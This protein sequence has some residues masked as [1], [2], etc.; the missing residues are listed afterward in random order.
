M[1]EVTGYDAAAAYAD[2]QA[3]LVSLRRKV[4]AGMETGNTDMVRTIMVELREFD[5]M[6]Y[7]RLRAE[8]VSAY[9]IGF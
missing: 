8:V 5:F 4:L 7:Q 9:G 1:D 2:K 6:A 3:V